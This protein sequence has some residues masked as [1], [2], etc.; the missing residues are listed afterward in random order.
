MTLLGE[1]STLSKQDDFRY[2]EKKFGM[3]EE[4]ALRMVQEF[5]NLG[6]IKRLLKEEKDVESQER[7]LKLLTGDQIDL[8]K[9]GE[10]AKALK[11][12]RE[13]LREFIEVARRVQRLVLESELLELTQKLMTKGS[14]QDEEAIQQAEQFKQLEANAVE[15][16][17]KLED[18]DE[19]LM[20]K[21]RDLWSEYLK[22]YGQFSRV[23][24]SNKFEVY[25]DKL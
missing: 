12:M 4:E 1:E 13:S 11:E 20:Q 3:K 16:M 15:K 24:K 9:V 2:F 7:K 21:S 5:K 10:R 23:K 18:Q 25:A 14:H 22:N 17:A 8:N 6:L 19:V